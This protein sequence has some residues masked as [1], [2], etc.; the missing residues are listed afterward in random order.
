MKNILLFLFFLLS[1]N[2]IHGQCVAD[3]GEDIHR[4][5]PDSV[6]QLGGNPT[7]MTGTAPYTY[8]WWM[9]PIETGSE[10]VP[11][12]HASDMLNDTSIAN[13]SFIY[14]GSFLSSDMTFY[15]KITDDMGC[16]SVD[17]ITVTTSIFN[18]HLIYH[19]YWINQGDSVYLNQVPN[20]GGGYG[21]ISYDWNPSYGL[22]DTSLATGFWASP[23]ISTAYTATVTD[24][25]GCTATAGEPLYFIWVNT[26][27]IGEN[28]RISIKLYPNPTSNIIFIE[29]DPNQP[30]VK[31]ELYSVS[32][33]KLANI[34]SLTN[35]VDLSS[36]A[37]GTYILKLYFS[38]G[39]SFQKIVKE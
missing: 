27:G 25:K 14:T 1:F 21:A 32:G 16:E 9:D 8:E 38:K 13:P 31:S 39:I 10:I 35:R 20:I 23:E 19:D 26:T 33:K 4:C 29:T 3:A 11:Y 24:S 17:S 7:A 36:Y 37:N 18:V 12:I 34:T 30:I 22:S 2:Y 5:S 6:V 15:L 28:K